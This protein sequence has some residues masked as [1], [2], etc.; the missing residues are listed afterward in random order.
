[1][2]ADPAAL[3]RNHLSVAASLLEQGEPAA[4][5]PHLE[6]YVAAFPRHHIVRAHF[7]ELLLRLHRLPEARRHFERFVADVQDVPELA[8]KH[9]IHC[10]S[11]LM[12][13]AEAEADEYQEHLHRGIGLYLLA[14][15]RAALGD[16]ESGE[17]CAESVLCRAAGELA[18]AR[19]QRRGEAQPCWYLYEVWSRLS[20]R[21][22]AMRHLREADAAAPFSYLT[23]TERRN[24]QL[25][26]LD[27]DTHLRIRR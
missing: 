25:A 9:L 16:V 20:Q 24:L 5:A 21:Q 19:H 1:V 14:C 6:K 12:E 27:R 22:P 3:A 8:S 13:I 26:C 11:R 15:E 4:A 18:L 7:A 17:L 10:H 23:P 2:S